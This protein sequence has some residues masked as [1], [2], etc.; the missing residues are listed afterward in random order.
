MLDAVA[1]IWFKNVTHMQKGYKG[2]RRC[3][4]L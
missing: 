4:L 2:K 1:A 3:L